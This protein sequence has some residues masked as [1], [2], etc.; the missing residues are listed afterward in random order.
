MAEVREALLCKVLDEVAEEQ[1]YDNHQLKVKGLPPTGAN[2][3]SQLFYGSISAPKK[4]D[5]NI[6]AKVSVVG[7]EL[8][9][10]MPFRLFEVESYVYTKLSKVFKKIEELNNVPEE[11]RLFMPKYY[12]G[13]ETFLE[14]VLVLQDLSLDGFTTHDRLKS[15][16]WEYASKSMEQLAKLHALSFAFEQMYPEEFEEATKILVRDLPEA[17]SP[18][19]DMMQGS[20]NKIIGIVREENRERIKIFF[21]TKNTMEKTAMYYKPLKKP[22]LAH[23]DYRMSNLMHKVDQVITNLNSWSK[24]Q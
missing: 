13:C 23:G 19:A 3:T 8:R 24:L 9:G 1:G 21:E 7:E 18:I 12:G 5:I 20:I 14:E 2:F 15:M 16:N 4:N 6:F 10:H 11:H 17:N 22:V